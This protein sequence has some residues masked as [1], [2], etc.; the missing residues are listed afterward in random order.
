MASAFKRYNDI[1]KALSA[2]LK[3]DGLTSKETGKKFSD[4]ASGFYHETEG[5]PLKQAIDNID[6]YVGRVVEENPLPPL[7]ASKLT[8]EMDYFSLESALQDE[9]FPNN[10]LINSFTCVEQH[11][12]IKDFATNYKKYLSAFYSFCNAEK[13]ISWFDSNDA[14]KAQLIP[15]LND[16]G[17]WDVDPKYIGYVIADLVAGQ[18]DNYG[19]I[20]EGEDLEFI[21]MHV[22]PPEISQEG[23]EIFEIEEGEPITE[24]VKKPKKKK[25][26]DK[27]RKKKIA[28]AK[29]KA[30][31]R[32]LEIKKLG[33][34]SKKLEVERL[35]EASTL[36]DKYEKLYKDG[37]INKTQYAKKVLEIG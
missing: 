1:Q 4:M 23:E 10:L 7:L 25:D 34:E 30:E 13:G 14:P 5:K 35:K 9:L 22:K 29:K 16:Y 17:Q 32:K 20:P 15:R 12:P 11:V 21:P 24:A 28:K 36:L 26:A 33:L 18:E 37:I 8:D 6:L 19:F 31:A 3:K 27:K 2:Q